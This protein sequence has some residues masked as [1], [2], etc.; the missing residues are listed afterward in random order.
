VVGGTPVPVAATESLMPT[1]STYFVRLVPFA[2]GQFVGVASNTVTIDTKFDPALV[3]KIAESLPPAA[4]VYELDLAVTAPTPWFAKCWEITAID[5][6]EF[7]PQH[8]WWNV[9]WLDFVK[10]FGKNVCPVCY[11]KSI[12]NTTWHYNFVGIFAGTG[13]HCTSPEE[14]FD[15]FDPSTYDEFPILGPLVSGLIQGV[16]SGWDFLVGIAT[17]LK[18][19]VVELVAE[20]GCKAFVKA[21]TKQLGTSPPAKTNDWC[22]KL[23]ETAV[24]VTLIAFGVPPTLPTFEQAMQAAKGD[25]AAALVELAED[26][27]IPCD[28]ADTVAELAGEDTLTCKAMAEGL[29]DEIVKTAK[30]AVSA[31]AAASSGIFFPPGVY[32]VPHAKGQVN[33]GTVA[34]TVKPTAGAPPSGLTCAATVT[35]WASYNA[36]NTAFGKSKFPDLNVGYSKNFGVADG[37]WVPSGV[38]GGPVIHSTTVTLP[39]L[40]KT[41]NTLLPVTRQFTLSKLYKHAEVQGHSYGTGAAN[42][43]KLDPKVPYESIQLHTEAELV[44]SVHAD[45]AVDTLVVGTMQGLGNLAVTKVI[46]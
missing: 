11:Q 2:G 29:I 20:V 4:N 44:T 27:G 37:L 35:M 24:D 43:V 36:P 28:E 31:S 32:A 7:D 26:L 22:N 39:K 6:N 3:G 10:L 1:P 34:I 23:A 9:A 5:P 8:Y 13:W 17:Y 33:P 42:W 12:G 18:A 25:L 41:G 38:Y 15:P 46:G 30:A 40:G 45:C 19:K 16:T 21:G 14:G